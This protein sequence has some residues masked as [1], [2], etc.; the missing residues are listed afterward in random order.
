MHQQYSKNGNRNRNKIKVCCGDR[1]ENGGSENEGRSSEEILTF[2]FREKTVIKDEKER[3]DHDRKV[4]NQQMVA[5]QA[6]CRDA[7]QKS[8]RALQVAATPARHCR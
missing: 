3:H 2:P 7:Q 1:H 6:A 8:I 5:D 4:M